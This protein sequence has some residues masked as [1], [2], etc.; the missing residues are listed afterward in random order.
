VSAVPNTVVVTGSGGRIGAIVRQALAGTYELRGIDRVATPGL[1]SALVAD[2]TDL[3][4]S[5]PSSRT[6]TPWC[7]WPPIPATRPTSGGTR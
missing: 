7:T 4:A 2:L 1:A 3:D 5:F 6:P